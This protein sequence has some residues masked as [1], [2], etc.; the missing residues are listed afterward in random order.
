VAQKFSK[1]QQQAFKLA[2][3]MLKRSHAPYSNFQVGAALFSDSKKVFSAGCNVENA[4]YGVTVCAERTAVL[5][6]VSDGHKKFDGIVIVARKAT[7][8]HLVYPCGVCRQTLKEFF[9]DSF[10][11]LL[12]DKTGIKK[13][14]TLGELFPH[15]FGPGDL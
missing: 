6:A 4:T 13:I 5:K 8:K 2:L 11:I 1:N 10:Q 12:A 15:G 14:T 3:D 7:A 9:P